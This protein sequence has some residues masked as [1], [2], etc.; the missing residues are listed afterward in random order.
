[1]EN[2]KEFPVRMK[3]RLENYDYSTCDT[4][5]ITICTLGKQNRF[6]KSVGATDGRPYNVAG[7]QSI[8]RIC[9]KT[10]GRNRLAKIIL[11]PHHPKRSG[12]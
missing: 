9:I 5:F 1:M 2:K 8:E 6:G 7:C 3:N 12:L 11:R 4:N 10:S